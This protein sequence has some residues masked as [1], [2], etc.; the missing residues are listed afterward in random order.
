MVANGNGNEEDTSNL[1]NTALRGIQATDSDGVA[2]FD[3]LFPGHYDGRTTHI[4]VVAHVGA[5]QLSNGTIAGGNI[6]HTGQFFFDQSV[7]D[8][9]NQLSPYS[10]IT[11]TV[12]TNAEDRVFAD[13]TVTE[14]SDPIFNYVLLGDT[15][16][17]GLFAWITVGV[18]LTA[19][20]TASPAAIYYETG[21]VSE[22]SSSGGIPG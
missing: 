3:S 18:D 5:T 6:T 7:T 1:N 14:G 15:V 2:T 4:H 11:A 19:N 21:G 9:I 10:D 20:Y 22:S 12:V 13:E 17:D 16:E 8:E